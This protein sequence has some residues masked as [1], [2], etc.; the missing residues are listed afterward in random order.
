M[1]DDS[2]C[3]S[4]LYIHHGSGTGGAP[5][6]LCFLMREL[7]R[8]RYAPIVCCHPA[9]KSAQDLFRRFG[10]ETLGWKLERFAHSAAGWWKPWSPRDLVLALRWARAFPASC[11]ELSALL[12]KVRPD[13]VHLNSITLLPYAPT[14]ARGGAKVVVHVREPASGGTLG[15]RRAWLRRIARKHVNAIIYICAD[16]RD[17][18]T[19]KDRVG[20]VVYNFV[21]FGEFDRGMDRKS[22]RARLGIY[23]DRPVILFSGGSSSDIKGVIPLLHAVAR[24]RD[25]LG[26]LT[27]LMPGTI[28]AAPPPAGLLKRMVRGKLVE[29]NVQETIA[30]LSLAD[31][32]VRSAFSHDMPTYYAACDVVAVPF[33]KP[34][35]ARA[36]IEAGAMAKPVV[37]SRI[38]GVAEV[39]QD[40]VTGLLVEPGNVPQ[41]ADALRR[42][43]TD[44]DLASRLG[45][46]GFTQARMK[47]EARRNAA[48]TVAVYEELFG[49]ASVARRPVPANS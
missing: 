28:S 12:T 48:A 26:R 40:G 41:L 17:R 7:D 33:T 35:F 19:G 42:V 4:I 1:P 13:L 5:L 24:V 29:Q 8:S 21:D 43:L 15:V 23:D 9:E 2:N 16:N 10:H 6:S 31:A 30:A 11:R 37:A 36:V 18:L 32:V 47:F 25:S 3:C 38:G 27:C 44:S 20:R 14:I 39:V 34:H 49:E 46:G 45:E 22:A